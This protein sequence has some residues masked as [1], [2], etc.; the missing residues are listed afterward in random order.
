[1]AVFKNTT[2]HPVVIIVNGSRKTIKPNATIHGPESLLSIPG[3]LMVDKTFKSVLPQINTDQNKR[4]PKKISDVSTPEL[5]IVE[6]GET[7]FDGL[8]NEELQHLEKFLHIGR[9]PSV[10]IAILTKN[11]IKLIRD[12]CESIFNNVKYPN[13]TILIAD[14]GTDEILVRDYYKEVKKKCQEKGFGYKLVQLKNYHFSKNYNEVIF[15][16]VNTDFVLIQNNDT[17]AKND[18]VT[19]MMKSAMFRKVASVGSRMYYPNNK[20]QHDGQLMFDK[21]GRFFNPG[22]LHLGMLKDHLTPKEHRLSF[23]DGNTAACVLVNVNDFKLVNGF[24]PEYGD[25]FQDVDLMLK[26]S[27]LKNRYNYCQRKAELIHLDNASRFNNGVD[28]NRVQ[29]M[30]KDTATL[31]NKVIK[32][33]WY[34]T[35]PENVEFTIITLV[36]K[37]DEYLKLTNSLKKQQGKHKIEL[38]AIPNFFN[39]YTSVPEAF[40]NATDISSG[41]YIIYMHQDVVV[42]KNWLNKIKKNIQQLDVERVQWGVIGPAGVT[43]DSQPHYYLLN[44]S[45]DIMGEHSHYRNEVFCLD[46]LCLIVQKDRD[47][48]FSE[49]HLNGFHFYGCDLCISSARRNLRNFAIDA[50]C[51]HNSEDG[52]KN[53]RSEKSYQQFLDQAKKFHIMLRSM[54]INQWRTTT[55][56]G[57]NDKILFF[58]NPPNY[59]GEGYYI[60]SV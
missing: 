21:L 24:S 45:M 20:I 37:I 60:L 27:H 59:T 23:V 10:T 26:L 49:D 46:E 51:F 30:F 55:A 3:L 15:K 57:K 35:K 28:P 41:R 43:L 18:Y 48:R 54:N 11:S 53:L 2:Q 58:I 12:C 25:I 29:H 52:R 36:N 38:I 50:Y 22:H 42:P 7:S 56:M 8:V 33:R 6:N 14:T 17:I 40:N 39:I 1:M 34:K 19:K 44:G 47:L 16:Y 31:K 9:N 4:I 32:N 5:Q 13:T